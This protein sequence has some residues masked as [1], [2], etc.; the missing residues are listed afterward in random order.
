[1]Q[2]TFELLMIALNH[3]SC[4]QATRN[5]ADHLRAELEA[6]LTRQQVE[7]D[8]RRVMATT[9]EAAAE[10]IVQQVSTPQHQKAD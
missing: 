9:L 7:A 5:R 6:Q 1:M 8:G 2:S 4:Y 3:P 10:A